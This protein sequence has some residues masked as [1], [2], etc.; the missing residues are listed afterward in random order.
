MKGHLLTCMAPLAR[1]KLSANRL[2]TVSWAF[3]FVVVVAN[4]RRTGGLNCSETITSG[5]PAARGINGGR[6]P[7]S[8][9]GEQSTSVAVPRNPSSSFMASQSKNAHQIQRGPLCP[10]STN[11]PPSTFQ[12]HPPILLIQP[13]AGTWHSGM[14][15]HPYHLVALRTNVKK[16]YGCGALFVKKFR[17]PPYNIVVKHVD[18]RVVG[19]DSNTGELLYARDFTNT[20]YHPNPSHIKRKNPFFDGSVLI[21]PGTHQSLDEGQRKILEKSGLIVKIDNL[22]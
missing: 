5:M 14:S 21:D 1:L 20:Y 4:K 10:A 16:C 22:R 11:P 17:Q 6:P 13:A 18:R 3:V 19:K 9:R 12:T 15:P 7:R 2:F 8:R